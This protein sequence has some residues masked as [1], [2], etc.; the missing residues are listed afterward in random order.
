MFKKHVPA[1][2]EEIPMEII[3]EYE[4]IKHVINNSPMFMI[5][6]ILHA[7]KTISLMA[8]YR[9]YAVELTSLYM[10]RLAR[11]TK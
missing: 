5:D 7:E 9:S 10:S 3:R 6:T 2:G 11:D 4:S 1:T 8:K